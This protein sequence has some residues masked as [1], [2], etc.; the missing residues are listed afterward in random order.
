MTPSLLDDSWDNVT[1][2]N[3]SKSFLLYLNYAPNDSTSFTAIGYGG[4]EQDSDNNNW[5]RGAE[6]IASRKFTPQLTGVVQLDYGIEDGVDANGK[7]AEWFAGGLW[8][9]YEFMEKLNAAFRADW[10]D[11]AAYPNGNMGSAAFATD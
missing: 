4:P 3:S 8:L 6:F 10:L 5:R 9:T 1:D 11:K 2:A 7:S